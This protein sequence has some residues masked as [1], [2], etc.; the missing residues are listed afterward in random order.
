MN[1]VGLS[2]F[3]VTRMWENVV[4]S[5]AGQ[6]VDATIMSECPGTLKGNQCNFCLSQSCGLDTSVVRLCPW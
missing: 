5:Y 3:L 1:E 2:H 4:T 6:R